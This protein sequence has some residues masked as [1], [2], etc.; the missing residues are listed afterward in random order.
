MKSSELRQYLDQ[1]GAAEGFTHQM[2]ES[3]RGGNI[4]P[5]QLARAN[6]G[7]V[8]AVVFLVLAVAALAGGLGGA[9]L[10]HDDLRPPISSVDLNAV[11]ALGGGGVLLGLAFAAV[12]G[13]TLRARGKRREAFARGRAEALEGPLQKTLFKGRRG[14][15][16]LY[17]VEVKGRRFFI[18]ST[19]YELLTHGATY[20]VY[21]VGDTLLSLEPVGASR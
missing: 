9:K 18:S 19:G 20:R 3:N 14:S 12:A 15:G 4:H 6:R 11:Y 2:L 1:L 8:A 7:L 13:L 21:C 10:F 5:G 17:R 16:N